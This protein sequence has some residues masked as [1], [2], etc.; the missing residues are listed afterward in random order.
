M[1]NTEEAGG[2]AAPFPGVGRP[3]AW[4]YSAVMAD[5]AAASTR[6]EFQGKETLPIL[7][8]QTCMNKALVF[9]VLYVSVCII[10]V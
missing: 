5:R 7:I 3:G 8:T 2:R 6:G 9:F 1:G 10:Q 4:R